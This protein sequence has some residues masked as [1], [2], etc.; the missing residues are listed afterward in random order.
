[1][2]VNDQKWV[3]TTTCDAVYPI[4]NALEFKW[5]DIIGKLGNV[6]KCSEP[7]CHAV[8]RAERQ[9]KDTHRYTSTA[10]YCQLME[11]A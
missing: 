1:M 5:N 11:I 6:T 10:H 9:L 7:N 4:V 2:W 8:V 3:I